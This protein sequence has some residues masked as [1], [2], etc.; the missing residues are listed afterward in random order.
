M[1][2]Q[3]SLAVTFF[4]SFMPIRKLRAVPCGRSKKHWLPRKSLV[5]VSDS[6]SLRP[7]GFIGSAMGSELFWSIFSGSPSVIADS[8][9]DAKLFCES[10]VIRKF[11]FSKTL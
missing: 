3:R 9:V 5:G 2:E 7:A 1:W 8:F 11:Q 6:K 4:G 10:A